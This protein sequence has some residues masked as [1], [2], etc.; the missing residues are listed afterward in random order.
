MLTALLVVLNR[1]SLRADIFAC[2]RSSTMCVVS[3]LVPPICADPKLRSRT[4]SIKFQRRLDPEPPPCA[5]SLTLR[6]PRARIARAQRTST[7]FSVMRVSS[8]SGCPS[9]LSANSSGSKGR[10]SSCT[11]AGSSPLRLPRR[12]NERRD[13][14]I[15]HLYLY[16]LR[17]L[18]LALGFGL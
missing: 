11:I 1:S 18:R 17:V 12:N 10:S 15:V 3:F 2:V 14:V 8:R 5:H 9:P 16:F 6:K 13:V 7:R 4:N